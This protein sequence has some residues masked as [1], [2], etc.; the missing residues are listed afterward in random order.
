MNSVAVSA[1]WGVGGFN[2]GNSVAPV[3]GCYSMLRT[4][5]WVRRRLTSPAGSRLFGGDG[6]DAQVVIRGELGA[7]QDFRPGVAVA[8][9][10]GGAAAPHGLAQ[11]AAR[12]DEAGESRWD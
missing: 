1:L 5:G 3:A 6:C 11:A 2:L 12:V 7:V 9:H 8:L 4:A 10:D